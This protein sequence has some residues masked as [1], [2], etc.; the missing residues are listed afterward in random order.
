LER[1]KGSSLNSI[2]YGLS[3]IICIVDEAKEI[4]KCM[5]VMG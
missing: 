5:L 1:D 4:K 3:M 2:G